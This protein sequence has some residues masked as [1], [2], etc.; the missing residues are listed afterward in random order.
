MIEQVNINNFRG[1]HRL[2]V[3]DLKRVNLLVGQNSSGKSAFLE[4]VFLSS[5]SAS[6]TTFFQLKGIRRMGGQVVNPVDAHG[7]R[8]IWEDLF[9]DFNQEKKVSIKVIGNPNSD[10]RT[11]SI[12]YITPLQSQE[13]P[14]GKQPSMSSGSIQQANAMPQIEFKWKRNGYSEVLSKPRFTSS[15]LQMDAASVNFF[16]AIWY[17]PG[18][19]ETPD[20]NAKRFSELEKRGDGTSTTVVNVI[21]KEFPFI[22]DLSIQYHAGVP[23]MFATLGNRGRKMPVPLLSDGINRLLGICTSLAY[24]SGGTVLIDQFEDGFHHSLLPSIWNSVYTLARNFKVQLFVS[25]HSRECMEAMLPTLRGNEQEF[26][27]LRASR[28]DTGCSI[29]SFAGSY[30]E[31]A[32]EQEFEVR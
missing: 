32:L 10:S 30:L 15:G 24:Y 29:K 13:L 2:E 9:F 20:E 17:T 26:C 5:S 7:Y 28:N 12:E 23:M 14:F 22:V 8:G 19:G 4:A 21:H 31:S 6:A 25:T 11:L 3:V 1:F 18:A 16:P 27:L